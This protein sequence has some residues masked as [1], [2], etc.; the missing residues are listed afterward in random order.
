MHRT[1]FVSNCTCPDPLCCARRAPR[2]AS[3]PYEEDGGA[4]AARGERRLEKRRD[5]LRRGE[6]METLRE[7]FGDQPETVRC[8]FLWFLVVDSVIVL[9]VF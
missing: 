1:D 7:E 6:V 3:V 2:L 5:K 8:M 9:I 4:G